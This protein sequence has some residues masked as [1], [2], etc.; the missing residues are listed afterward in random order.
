MIFVL[1]GAGIS[2]ES[3]LDTFRDKD[4]LWSKVNIEDVATPRA[5][6]KDPVRVLE[7][8]D[9]RRKE[10]L[11]GDIKPNPAHQALARLESQISN[12]RAEKGLKKPGLFLVTQNVDD[13]HERGGSKQVCHTH[14]S[15][16]WAKC[17]ACD[18]KFKWLKNLSLE[19]VCP[20]C[21]AQGQLRPDVVW[22]EEMP[23]HLE[24]I[25]T[26]LKNCH[27]FVSIGTSGLVYPAAS[28]LRVAKKLKVPTLE[29]NIAPTGSAN[30]YDRGFYGPASEAVPQWV[31]EVISQLN[32]W[33]FN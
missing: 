10:L 23:Y 20:K 11:S 31:D 14:G 30:L 8:Y 4:G 22:F 12:Y 17:Q 5:F 3:G 33:V 21:Q 26:N 29:I 13:L 15:L 7:F 25:E 27:L 24:E 6:K 19:E 1:T 28:Y 16:L 2:R 9:F 32:L 18:H